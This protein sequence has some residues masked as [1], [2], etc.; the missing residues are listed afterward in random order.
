VTIGT[1]GR[2]SAALAPRSSCRS[3]VVPLA[4]RAARSSRR[5]LVA[6]PAGTEDG[7]NTSV[8]VGVERA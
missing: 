8:G 1:C 2:P 5:T 7:R 3:L 4:R 6:P